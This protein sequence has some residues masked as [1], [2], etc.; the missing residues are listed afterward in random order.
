MKKVFIYALFFLTL[1]FGAS[2]KAEINER[3]EIPITSENENSQSKGPRMPERIPISCEY[4]DGAL[5]FTFN[6]DLGAVSVVVTNVNTG[7]YRQNM[8]PATGI[9]IMDV[10]KDSGYY[11][12]EMITNNK[13]YYG[14]FEII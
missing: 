9:A 10:S 5:Y 4:V 11:Y 1:G 2:A 12:I 6:Y 7:E 3:I 13:V 8:L 14:N